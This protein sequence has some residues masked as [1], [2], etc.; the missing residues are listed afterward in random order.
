MVLGCYIK[1]RIFLYWSNMQVSF[2]TNSHC[3]CMVLSVPKTMEVGGT[4]C[5]KLE[6]SFSQS[7]EGPWRWEPT[8]LTALHFVQSQSCGP[9]RSY[10]ELFVLQQPSCSQAD[11]RF[12]I[13][14]MASRSNIGMV[15]FKG[16]H[17]GSS[18][19]P[20]INLQ[21]EGY[22]ML[23]ICG[24]SCTNVNIIYQDHFQGHNYNINYYD[25]S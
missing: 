1:Q 17:L 2:R 13:L 3:D 12:V 10:N 24:I 15:P 7:T 18:C 20:A 22:I 11:I 14:M 21:C 6:S 4:V 19:Q 25:T 8:I 5:R 23:I 16:L 9:A